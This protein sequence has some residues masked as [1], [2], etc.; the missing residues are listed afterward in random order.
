MISEDELRTVAAARRSCDQFTAVELRAV[1]QISEFVERDFVGRIR[2][3][4]AQLLV[5]VDLY[6]FERRP[7]KSKSTRFRQRIA[8]EFDVAI[9]RF[10]E[11]K[12][13][14]IDEILTDE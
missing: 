1:R 5:W 6:V 2:Q 8:A 9:R 14:R 13:R 12:L 7:E 3:R 4:E 11:L 10:C